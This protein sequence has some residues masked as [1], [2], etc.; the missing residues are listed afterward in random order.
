MLKYGNHRYSATEFDQERMRNLL[1]LIHQAQ[2]LLFDEVGEEFIQTYDY[3]G[4]AADALSVAERVVADY[5]IR[6]GR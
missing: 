5:G 1:D 6:R 3:W 4:E 2:E